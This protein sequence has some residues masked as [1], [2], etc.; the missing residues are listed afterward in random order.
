MSMPPR[1]VSACM[2]TG[3]CT[4]GCGVWS[5]ITTQHFRHPNLSFHCTPNLLLPLPVSHCTPN[6]LLPA[7]RC[8]SGGAGL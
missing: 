7:P 3:V 5:V 4:N 2:R 1:L 8:S 6:L